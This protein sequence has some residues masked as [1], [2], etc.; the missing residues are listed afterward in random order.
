LSFGRTSTK[1]NMRFLCN[2]VT[3]SFLFFVNPHTTMLQHVAF[4][5]VGS[6]STTN[7]DSIH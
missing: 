3:F 7:R 6:I 2:Y 5:I 4:S 1:R